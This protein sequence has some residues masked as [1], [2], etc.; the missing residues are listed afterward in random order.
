MSVD[1]ARAVVGVIVDPTILRVYHTFDTP[2][3]LQDGVQ[4]RVEAVWKV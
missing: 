4:T 3:W 1:F 2:S